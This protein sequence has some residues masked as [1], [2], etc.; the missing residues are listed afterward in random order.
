MTHVYFIRHAQSDRSVRDGRIRP[1]TEQGR[2]DSRLVTA[3]LSGKRI[4][5]VFSSPFRRAVETVEDFAKHSGLGV[6]LVEEF[7]ER[8]GDS[9]LEREHPDFPRFQERQWA[10][11]T[12]TYSDGEC[13]AEVQRRNISALEEL[14]RE[15]EGKNLAIGTHGM[16]LAVI[17]NY[18]DKSFGFQEFLTMKELLPWVARI[19]FEHGIC[20]EIEQIDLFRQF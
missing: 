20:M 16:A 2:A 9:G 10:D 8:R 12:Y 6:R 1:L 14:L 13:L 4:D 18:Y 3:Y 7:R 17:L 11:F 19:S 15:W 5:A